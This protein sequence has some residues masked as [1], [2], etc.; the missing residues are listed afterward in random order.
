MRDLANVDI[1]I[2]LT[3]IT[4]LTMVALSNNRCSFKHYSKKLFFSC[5]SMAYNFFSA[6]N[7]HCKKC[8]IITKW[9]KITLVLS[10]GPNFFSMF[11]K[12]TVIS[13]RQSSRPSYSSYSSIS[14]EIRFDN[15]SN[16]RIINRWHI[17]DLLYWWN[18]LVI[19]GKFRFEEVHRN[20]ARESTSS[21]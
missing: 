16:L 4:T 18:C 3:G 12:T 13:I 10:A 6:D 20:L 19:L 2:I 17:K 7:L 9:Q 1:S 5:R 15:P 21:K 11:P 14:L 8:L